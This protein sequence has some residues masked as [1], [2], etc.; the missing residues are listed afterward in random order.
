M[1]ESKEPVPVTVRRFPASEDPESESLP[2]TACVP[3]TVSVIPPV[4]QVK[5]VKVLFPLRVVVAENVALLKL[6]SP[7]TVIFAP[8]KVIVPPLAENP[9]PEELLLLQLPVTVKEDSVETE[10]FVPISRFAN[11]AFVAFEETEIICPKLP[12][13]STVFPESTANK[14]APPIERFPARFR[15]CL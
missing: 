7:L 9:L 12:S 4:V 10:E 2:L 8:M 13:K 3:S 15:L 6:L 5:S 11:S 14:E 1:L